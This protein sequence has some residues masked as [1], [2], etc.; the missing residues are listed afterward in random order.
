MN[1]DENRLPMNSHPIPDRIPGADGASF[2]LRRM[3][4]SDLPVM[5]AYR[6]RPDVAQYQ[7][8][9]TDWDAD[10]ARRL[11]TSDRL[12]THVV[13]GEWTQ[14]V[15]EEVASG[16]ACG[17]VGVHFVADQP[18]TVEIGVTLAPQYQ[19]RGAATQSITSLLGW[20][21]D[22]LGTHRVVGQADERNAPVRRLLD[23]LGFRHEATFVDADW[24]KGAWTTLCIYRDAAARM[25]AHPAQL[26]GQ[27]AYFAVA[28]AT[29]RTARVNPGGPLWSLR[30]LRRVITPVI[31]RP[32]RCRT[33]PPMSWPTCRRCRPARPRWCRCSPTRSREPALHPGRGPTSMSMRWS[34]RARVCANRIPTDPAP[35]ISPRTHQNAPVIDLAHRARPVRSLRSTASSRG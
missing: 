29:K 3:R 34:H 9:D 23:R 7:S 20:L 28:A 27:I 11:Y 31:D 4:E 14:M 8:W 2:V 22:E 12:M 13:A 32:R 17:D 1:V 30:H 19:G 10:A 33:W 35:G 25:G 18:D 21:F 24:F 6:S 15:V 5:V 16:E 26:A